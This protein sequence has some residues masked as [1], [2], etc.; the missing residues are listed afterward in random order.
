MSVKIPGRSPFSR[1][2]SIIRAPVKSILL[3]CLYCRAIGR[4]WMWSFWK[5][6]WNKSWKYDSHDIKFADFTNTIMGIFDSTSNL[7]STMKTFWSSSRTYSVGLVLEK[8]SLL[9]TNP[10][11]IGPWFLLR[12]CTIVEDHKT[13]G[14]KRICIHLKTFLAAEFE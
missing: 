4:V 10:N 9:N 7:R 14:N 3:I 11:D 5:P 8:S 13:N 6:S 12:R 2:H 1:R